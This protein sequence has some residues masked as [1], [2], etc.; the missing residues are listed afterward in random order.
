MSRV[1][2]KQYFKFYYILDMVSC[3]ALNL[4]T[5]ISMPRRSTYP[6]FLI[7][8]IES[9]VPIQSKPLLTLFWL[10]QKGQQETQIEVI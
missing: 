2:N 6:I 7:E 4:K 10:S 8:N 5:Q 3:R 1:A 9:G